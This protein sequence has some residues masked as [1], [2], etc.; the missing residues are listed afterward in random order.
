MA[1]LLP[2]SA[3]AERVGFKLMFRLG[4]ALF[5][6]ASLLCAFSGNLHSLVA[7]RM[8]QG[9]GAS[10]M[11]CL[12][13][14]L[15]RHIYPAHKLAA[16]ISINAMTVG[17]MSVVG[18]SVGAAILSVASWQWIF[19]FTVPICLF[20]MYAAGYLPEAASRSKGR[21]DYLSAILN[22]FTFAILLIGWMPSAAIP[23]VACSCLAWRQSAAMCCCDAQG[24]KKRPWC[25][26]ICFV[27]LYSNTPSS[28]LRSPL[29]RR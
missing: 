26:L 14:G 16:G 21:F 2:L 4:L 28:S 3:V 1:T 8:L 24:H 15:V 29:P 23:V 10:S 12:F 25:R 20:A 27:T 7:A 9:L 5:T 18:P 11:M 19:G 17:V 22:I 13:G 6:I